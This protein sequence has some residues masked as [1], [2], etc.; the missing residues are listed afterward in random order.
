MSGIF[1]YGQIDHI[2]EQNPSR[3][4]PLSFCL[5]VNLLICYLKSQIVWNCVIKTNNSMTNIWWNDGNQDATFILEALATDHHTYWLSHE[6]WFVSGCNQSDS[7]IALNCK[8]WTNWART[9]TPVPLP[10]WNLMS[11]TLWLGAPITHH[12][13]PLLSALFL[14]LSG[15]VW[16]KTG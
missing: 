13:S 16:T 1:W 12:Q 3:Q 15:E 4:T 2:S 9:N 10:T 7:D 6:C 14:L 11:C 8:L 5:L